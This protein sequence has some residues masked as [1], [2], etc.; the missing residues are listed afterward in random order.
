[1]RIG[2]K[3]YIWNKELNRKDCIVGEIIVPPATEILSISS[4]LEGMGYIGPFELW[5]A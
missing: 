1:M 4:I 5:M 3:G 2:Y